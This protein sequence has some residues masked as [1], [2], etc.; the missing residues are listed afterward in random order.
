LKFLCWIENQILNFK[1]NLDHIQR[2]LLH[3]VEYFNIFKDDI[4]SC[5]IILDRLNDEKIE[6]NHIELVQTLD[7]LTHGFI[8]TDFL[9]K[10]K[11]IAII[12][13]CDGLDLYII[14]KTAEEREDI[15][16]NFMEY[17]N[18]SDIS[19]IFKKTNVI[20]ISPFFKIKIKLFCSNFYNFMDLLSTLDFSHLKYLLTI[21]IVVHRFYLP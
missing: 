9:T 8:S 13:D 15:F 6:L 20:I 17:C 14:G 21:G 4:Y 5:N 10:F 1:V 18:C 7:E 2:F 19:I 12:N 16:Y 3:P 11:N